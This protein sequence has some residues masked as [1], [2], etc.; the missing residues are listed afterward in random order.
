MRHRT[1]FTPREAERIGRSLGERFDRFSP[2]DLARGMGIELEH[3]T[4]DPRTDVTHDDPVMTAKIA[5]AHLHEMADYYTRLARIERHVPRGNPSYKKLTP[6][7]RFQRYG[8]G[9]ASADEG[10]QVV[11][12]DPWIA[13]N[14]NYEIEVTVAPVSGS[15][16]SYW[17]GRRIDGTSRVVFYRSNRVATEAIVRPVVD[18]ASGSVMMTDEEMRAVG[19]AGY[20]KILRMVATLREHSTAIHA[21]KVA[22][23]GVQASTRRP[24]GNPAAQFA[25]DDRTEVEESSDGTAAV[26]MR[27]YGQRSPQWFGLYEFIPRRG[28]GLELSFAWHAGDGHVRINRDEVDRLSA[29]HVSRLE[30][31]AARAAGTGSSLH[32]PSAVRG[33]PVILQRRHDHYFTKDLRFEA[34]PLRATLMGRDSNRIRKWFLK[35]NVSGELSEHTD[36]SRVREHIEAVIRYGK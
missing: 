28:R 31:L 36:M 22:R 13:A 9:A 11:I 29:E 24:R 27:R 26:T 19:I 15:G 25:G 16:R 32:N 20:Q 2:T 14:G 3:G 23:R 7:R 33:N 34:W 1:R 17:M 12:P 5:L 4:R 35:D 10:E 8:Q 6:P 30:R 18:W 21:K